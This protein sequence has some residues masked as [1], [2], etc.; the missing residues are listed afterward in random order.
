[1]YYLLPFKYNIAN[2]KEIITNDFGDY[3]IMP[4]GT[5]SKIVNRELKPSDNLYKDLLASF[6]ICEQPVPRL[7][8]NL[9]V[10]LST[11]KSFLDN[12]TALHIFVVTLRCNQNCVYC[13]ASSK[14]CD[15]SG[16]DMSKEDLFRSIDHMY[17]SP[18][19]HLTMEF[20]G[21]E[22]TLVPELI[23]EG[24]LYSEGKK[25][26]TNK[27]VTYVICT[28][29]V[30]IPDHLL[31]FCSNYNVVF[32]TS[33]DGPEWLHNTNRGKSDSY[34]NCLLY[35]SPSPRDRSV[36]RMPSSA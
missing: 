26:Q 33:L 3:Q 6:I 18:A 24:I 9:S 27:S 16:V 15:K 5:V 7:I 21:G 1:M 34:Q 12:Y 14:V 4:R 36:S 22:P 30:N 20:Q 32:S 29:S 25:V 11:R 13:Q 23:K 10:R 8:D 17:M 2:G 31:E 35:T 28:N 19:P